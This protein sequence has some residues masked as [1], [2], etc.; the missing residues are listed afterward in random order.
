M[1]HEGKPTN[2]TG[3]EE[4]K[5][6]CEQRKPDLYAEGKPTDDGGQSEDEEKLKEPCKSAVRSVSIKSLEFCV[7]EEGIPHIDVQGFKMS[8][9]SDDKANPIH[10]AL[11]DLSNDRKDK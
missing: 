5:Q 6:K 7:D 3:C 9:F 11:T 8:G 2:Q 4:E 1:S 10:A